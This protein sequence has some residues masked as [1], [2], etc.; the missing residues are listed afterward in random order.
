MY[1]YDDND[2]SSHLENALEHYK[3]A[4]TYAM[5]LDKYSI[6]KLRIL[7]SFAKFQIRCM[8]DYYR[9]VLFAS[10]VI[11]EIKESENE[12]VIAMADKFKKLY[13]DNIDAYNRVLKVYYPEI[14]KYI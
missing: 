14:K 5:K 2:K 3:K 8:K 1:L 10:N 9:S 7:L 4:V 6:I 11:T 12:E 13:E